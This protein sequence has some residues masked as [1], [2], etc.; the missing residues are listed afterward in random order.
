M[1]V[2][3]GQLIIS[4]ASSGSSFKVQYWRNPSMSPAYLRFDSSDDMR[5]FL[6]HC[7]LTDGTPEEVISRLST[8]AELMLS[9]L[10]SQPD[11][12]PQAG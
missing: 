4:K 10:E 1:A 2:W 11:V 6:Q 5:R 12:M 9:T 3:L 8:Q 7:R